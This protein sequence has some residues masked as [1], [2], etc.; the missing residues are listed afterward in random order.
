MT[1]SNSNPAPHMLPPGHLGMISV[2]TTEVF[3]FASL[4]V[5][6]LAYLGKSISGPLPQD[7]LEMGLVSINT[8]ALLVSSVTVVFA[9]NALRKGNNTRFLL[10]MLLTVLLGAWF[11]VGTA[12]EWQGLI[13]D[14]HLAL[15]TNLFGTT[16]YTLVGFHAFHVTFGVLA[17]FF[18]WCCG[19][20][21]WIQ[22]HHHQNI[23]YVS[24]YWHFVDVVWIAVFLVVYVIGR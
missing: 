7:T 2:I 15:Q 24:W 14:K 21:G 13:A 16:Y 18:I 17:L 22:K 3:F 4:I 8:V 12:I 20:F 6:Y 9:L 23:E 10:F 11:L 1:P 5:V 19:V